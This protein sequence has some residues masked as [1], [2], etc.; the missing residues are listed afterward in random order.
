[1]GAWGPGLYQDDVTCDVKDEYINRLRVGYSNNKATEELIKCN[2][3]YIED[4]DDSPLFWFALADTQWRYG[5]LSPKVK[6]EA[7]NFIKK[8]N[9]LERW[10]EENPKQYLKRKQVL[11]ELEE[12]LNSPQPIE[13]K[14]T[15]LTPSRSPWEVG[16]ILL[17]QIKCYEL[18]DRDKGNPSKE[19]DY[20]FITN[21][22]WYNKYVLFRVI[23]K[24]RTNK[25]SLPSE[26]D[27]EQTVIS[28]YNW[29]GDK[30]PNLELI[31]DLKFI[32]EKFFPRR[33]DT[34]QGSISFN[35]RELK[36]LD[37]QVIKSDSQYKKPADHIMSI[38]GIL[39]ENIY[40]FDYTIIQLLEFAESSGDLID[41]TNK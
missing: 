11:E 37:F 36:R 9:D 23:G 24:T 34:W 35:K 33:R 5:R 1:M 28:I 15:K 14:V 39:W 16:D 40:T 21:H 27:D 10:K 17:Y 6:E 25:G 41:D 38:I 18:K 26:Y 3:S 30:E 7:L 12:R 13:K 22:K 19:E 29:V 32:K 8:G 31:D 2:I 20:N 4:E